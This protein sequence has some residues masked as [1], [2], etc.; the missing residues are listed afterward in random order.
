MSELATSVWNVGEIPYIFKTLK[1]PS[2]GS[3]LPDF[4]SF[5]LSVDPSTGTIIQAYD[6]SV[7]RANKAAYDIGSEITGVMT[8]QGIG[9]EY[10]DDFL[11]FLQRS[12]GRDGFKGLRVLDVGSGT[13]YLIHRIKQLGGDVLGVDPGPQ[14]QKSA[15][16]YGVD[17]I[18]DFFPSARIKGKFDLIMSYAL[19][20]HVTNPAGILRDMHRSLADDGMIATAVPNDEPC[21]VAGDIS[22]FFH[23]HWNYYSEPTLRATLA[24]VGLSSDTTLSDF[25]GLIYSAARRAPTKERVPQPETRN[26][27]EAI[28]KIC[29]S[30]MEM[31]RKILQECK[32]RRESVGVYVPWRIVNYLSL[33]QKKTKLPEINFFDD[34]PNVKGTYL[35]GFAIP[36]QDR[37]ELLRD[38]P[39]LLLIM[40]PSFGN[41]I[42]GELEGRLRATRIITFNDLF[43]I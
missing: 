3:G 10:A 9:R 5:K 14:F 21:I 8:D 13:G 18:Q 41:K 37:Q 27:M 30:K 19:L 26:K 39:S 17:V 15:A 4:L 34:D 2:N 42:K 36:I 25:G 38:P 33:I 28:M 7:E 6:A 11:G 24:S 31:I 22:P 1:T 32:E 43:G 12:L 29:H 35:P 40:S 20:E 16:R 23:E